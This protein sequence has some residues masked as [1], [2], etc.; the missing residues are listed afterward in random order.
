MAVESNDKKLS[1]FHEQED[2]TISDIQALIDNHAEEG[3]HLELKRANALSKENADKVTN[4]DQS[5]VITISDSQQ[6]VVT[7][8]DLQFI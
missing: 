2:Y 3:V 1:D 8:R 6:L 7:S 5:K 4:R